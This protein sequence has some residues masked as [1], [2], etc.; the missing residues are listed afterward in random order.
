[1]ATMKKMLS[2]REYRE[3][4]DEIS[5]FFL[6]VFSVYSVFSVLT[7][8]V[9]VGTNPIHAAASPWFDDFHPYRA[10][11]LLQKPVS[12]RVTID[13]TPQQLAGALKSISLDELTPETIAFDRA[14]L[15][16]PKTRTIVGQ[17]K[18]ARKGPP[19]DIDGDFARLIAK[20]PS[21]W[22]GFDPAT[23]AFEK[24]QNEA[25]P[26]AALRLT[27]PKPTNTKLSQTVKLTQ[28]A[29]YLLDYR[30]WSDTT[31]YNIVLDLY[32]LSKNYFPKLPGSYLPPLTPRGQ[33]THF[34]ALKKAAIVE[35][36]LRIEN[37]FA[38]ECRIA[39][40][41]LQPVA[42]TLIADL[43]PN[44]D[45]L[46]LYASALGGHKMVQPTESMLVVA[47][48]AR[49]SVKEVRGERA[50]LN[51]N[52]ILIEKS[53]IRAWTV[54]SEMPLIADRIASLAPAKATPNAKVH[55][56]L[57]RGGAITL[58]IA[59]DTKTPLAR[60]LKAECDLTVKSTF[61]RIAEIPLFDNSHPRG[62]KIGSRFDALTPIDYALIPPATAGVHLVAVTFSADAKA[63]P[64]T[65]AGSIQLT[66]QTQEPSTDTIE[67]PVNLTISPIVLRPMWH[68]GTLFGPNPLDVRVGLDA[69]TSRVGDTPA[70]FHG[71]KPGSTELARKYIHRMI[72]F[73]VTPE[74]PPLKMPTC[75]V[76]SLG[77]GKAPE[78]KDW[79]FTEMG[80]AIDEF[81]LGRDMPWFM[82]YRSNGNL[83]KSLWLP[84]GETYGFEDG[85]TAPHWNKLPRA[86]YFK[87]V[88]DYFE[89][90][91]KYLDEKGILDRAVYVVD[92]SLPPTYPLIAEY[93]AA[94]KTQPHAGRLRI[95]NTN[96]KTSFFTQ[97][98][99]HGRIIMDEPI[100]VPM[101]SN[102]DY[103]NYFE[104]EMNARMTHP[105]KSQW[106][107][108]VESTHFTLD[109]A[110]LSTIVCPLK[111]GHFGASGW[112]CWA[113]TLWSWPAIPTDQRGPRWAVGP[114]LNPWMNPFYHHGP[115]ALSFFYPPDP[116]GL[117]AVPN[118]TI[119]PS[120]RL[121]LMRDGI[122][123][124]ALLEVLNRGV[125]DAG[126]PISVH[127]K[128][129]RA[130]RE[131]MSSLWQINPVQWHLSYGN[132]RKANE[133]LLQSAGETP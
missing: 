2:H 57:F 41:R 102:D 44:T 74:N 107:Y 26:T 30:I 10:T 69:G 64:G 29:L 1:M 116:R 66:I 4:R 38:G 36:E 52:G 7:S 25:K 35:P 127:E 70:E 46:E 110:G 130:A 16:D 80:N 47:P 37:V 13:L 67:I 106:V 17:F 65:S 92:E 97:V 82:L 33:W 87:L 88:A 40:I 60:V 119:I 105:G 90:I 78:L 126:N 75:T 8:L 23:M 9:F 83:M 19:I 12:G 115:G 45:R 93:I 103:L 101:P 114:A 55:A 100:D 56:H 132:F 58:L 22:V 121:S 77:A 95:G 104:P 21:P 14:T 113:A 81:I 131:A 43:P 86:E 59:I 39:S 20:K 15:V 128:S 62:R 72:D 108:Y 111:L 61:E 68:F 94:L 49:A 89:N 48:V 18:L 118:D 28:D 32:D 50:N 84:N 120:Y 99:E 24:L 123:T 85:G 109:H 122:Q 27:K 112:Y 51:P 129:L 3:H 76:V 63:K 6:S 42:W 124:R 5:T 11:L 31:D 133:L 117:S 53:S 125:D 34:M 79:D 73:S 91:A 98:D 96:D 71:M 54:P